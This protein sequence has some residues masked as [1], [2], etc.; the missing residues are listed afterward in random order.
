MQLD[1]G[2]DPPIQSPRNPY[3]YIYIPSQKALGPSKPTTV[4]NHPPRAG[5]MSPITVSSC[6]GRT[7]SFPSMVSPHTGD[8]CFQV[9]KQ[10]PVGYMAGRTGEC[11]NNPPL[12]FIILHSVES[13]VS[14][15]R[16]IRPQVMAVWPP[17]EL[18]PC[19]VS[20]FTRLGQ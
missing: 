18:P 3:I 1:P 10:I 2:P 15:E 6:F 8:A 13:L 17:A 4:S 20:S 11:D 9:L 16:V 5:R 14:L 12:S 19:S 7:G